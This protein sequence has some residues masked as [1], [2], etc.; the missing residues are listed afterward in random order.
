M[1][2]TVQPGPWGRRI[3]KDRLPRAVGCGLRGLGKGS[4]EQLE[5]NQQS[6]K[7]DVEPAQR[8]TRTWDGG[9]GGASGE[10]GRV[11]LLS[12]GPEC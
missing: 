2:R 8:P 9:C 11:W 10:G 4:F 1:T 12:W 6:G 7:Q 3:Q 5:A